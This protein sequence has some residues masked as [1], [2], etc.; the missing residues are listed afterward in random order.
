MKLVKHLKFHDLMELGLVKED[1][2][3]QF[4]EKRLID[5]CEFHL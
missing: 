5:R 3:P 2:L 4:S 1:E